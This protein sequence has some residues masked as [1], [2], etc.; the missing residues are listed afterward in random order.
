MVVREAERGRQGSYFRRLPQGASGKNKKLQK[1][2]LKIEN[3]WEKREFLSIDNCNFV[4]LN[5]LKSSNQKF[6]E[7]TIEYC[8]LVKTSN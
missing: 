1:I 5:L 3:F 6:C 4:N 2:V 7:L 8:Q